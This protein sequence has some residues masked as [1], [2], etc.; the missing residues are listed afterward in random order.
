MKTVETP[1]YFQEPDLERWTRAVWDRELARLIDELS[2]KNYSV[3]SV[4]LMET[5]GRFVAKAAIDRG[6][7]KHPVIALCGTGN[8]GGDGLV[9]ARVLHD[10][11]VSVNVVIV[12]E[13][14]KVPSDLFTKQLATITA[15][16]V[17]VTTWRPGTIP[18]FGLTRP[19]IIDA[20]SGIGFKP[21]CGGQMLAAM[22]EASKVQG[23]TVIAVD[24][25]SGVSPDDGSV[26]N[27]PLPAHETITFGSSRPIHRLMPSAACC[28][29]V[30]VNDIGFP[31]AA[32]TD[33]QKRQSPIWLEVDPQAVLRADPWAALP[34]SA[35]KYDRGH[36]LVIGGSPGK[37]G[38]PVMTALAALRSGAGWCSVAPP[39]G[40]SPADMP[41]P[42]ELTIE[43]FYDGDK[44]DAGA[45]ET[46]LSSRRVN[47]IIV[48][49][50][51]MKQCLDAA[52]LD[53]LRK[54]A[55]SGGNVLLDAGALHG[56]VPLI[57]KSGALPKGR[58]IL[59]PHHGEW[60][61]LQDISAAPPLTPEGVRS[62][63]EYAAKIGA[64]IIYKNAAPVIVTPEKS[65]PIICASG[66]TTLARAGSGD[67]LAGII[68]AHLAVGCSQDFAA[69]RAYTLLSRAAW[70]AAQDVGEDAV[71]GSDILTRIGIAGRM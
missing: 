11:G 7:E 26:A 47:C 38:A 12:D 33:A 66:N 50:G 45:L 69:A 36:I 22:T 59:T 62:A 68:G 25:P 39:R 16:K 2:S 3:A 51:W 21:P 15:M 35:H 37:V 8:N 60:I 6:A 17:P 40:E 14:G 23:A 13:P 58:F 43:N 24:L 20:I 70:I 63:S 71:L 34:K 4:A 28:G 29:H 41:I 30:V 52:S 32:V 64:H 44:I 61:K 57:L 46:F 5:A 27:A 19:I 10:H 42:T 65:A 18:S 1:H 53:V 49:P 48:G 54:F 56:I 55:Q 9:A 31:K 67:L